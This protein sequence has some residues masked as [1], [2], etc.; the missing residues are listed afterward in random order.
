MGHINI[1]HGHLIDTHIFTFVNGTIFNYIGMNL[2]VWIGKH[3]GIPKDNPFN[4]KNIPLKL[5]FKYVK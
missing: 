4:F 5:G 3:R 2:K 1:N